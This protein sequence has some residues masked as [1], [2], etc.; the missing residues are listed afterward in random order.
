MHTYESYSI[1]SNQC[2]LLLCLRVFYDTRE[3]SAETEMNDIQLEN[4]V[5]SGIHELT[6][7]AQTGYNRAVSKSNYLTASRVLTA[8][9]E[10][11]RRVI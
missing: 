1:V 9:N 2:C 7:S 3:H 10:H 5:P 8:Y 6:V 11:L 4:S